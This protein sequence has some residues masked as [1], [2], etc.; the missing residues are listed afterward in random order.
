M[1]RARLLVGKLPMAEVGAVVARVRPPLLAAALLALALTWQVAAL[2][3]APWRARSPSAAMPS[4][5]RAPPTRLDISSIVRAQ[6]FGAAAAD[7]SAVATAGPGLVLVGVIAEENPETGYAMLGPSADSIALFRAGA[8]VQAGMHLKSVYR[9]YVLL[10]RGG[11]LVRL[12]MKELSSNP[13]S[14]SVSTSMDGAAAAASVAVNRRLR[15]LPTA[16][17]QMG[18]PLQPGEVIRTQ[19][20]RAEDGTVQG[21]RLFTGPQQDVFRRSGLQIG[22]VVIAVDGS[23]LGRGSRDLTQVL[24]TN[25]RA[26]LTVLRDGEQRDFT[27]DLDN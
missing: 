7:P 27:L 25:R 4:A 1:S 16:A 5:T 6:L 12:Q 3:S 9:D 2:V 17:R 13:G 11:Q 20:A 19:I 21:Y 18:L 26:R 23:R 8:E 24:K 10:E 22:D 14:M 15:V